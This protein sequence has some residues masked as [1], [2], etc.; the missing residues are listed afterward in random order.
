[1]T[2][3]R[4]WP[5]MGIAVVLLAASLP[6]AAQFKVVGPDGRV[7]YTDRPPP[8]GQGSVTSIGR[9]STA[10]SAAQGESVSLPL[11][12]RQIASRF[13]VLLYAGNDCPPCDQSRQWLQQRGIPYTEKRVASDDDAA[14]LDRLVGGRTIPSLT[15]GGQALRG[16]ASADWAAYLDAAGYPKESRLPRGWQAPPATP[17]V[18]RSPA[19]AAAT[20]AGRP[21]VQ[22]PAARPAPPPPPP[23]A[24]AEGDAA[25]QEQ[26]PKIRF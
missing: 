23:P 5:S 18:E 7:T 22:T 10:N 6:A 20:A 8:A 1:M 21:E 9:G 26:E 14:A 15:I 24:P 19:Q 3:H 4:H 25:G 13:P 2:S 16:F 12:L 11:E 17:V